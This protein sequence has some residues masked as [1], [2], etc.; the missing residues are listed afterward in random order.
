MYQVLITRWSI[1]QTENVQSAKHLVVSRRR[2]CEEHVIHVNFSAWG[3]QGPAKLC[4]FR[5]TFTHISN[6]LGFMG[7]DLCIFTRPENYVKW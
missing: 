2:L 6:S 3:H 5:H 4:L 7:F 1:F